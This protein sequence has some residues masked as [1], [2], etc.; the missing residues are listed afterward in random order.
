MR[1]GPK[2][3]AR[4]FVSAG[5][6]ASLFLFIGACGGSYANS[7]EASGIE[8]LETSEQ[9]ALSGSRFEAPALDGPAMRAL[10]RARQKKQALRGERGERLT[11]LRLEAIDAYQRVHERWPEAGG[12]TAEAAFR[13]GELLRTGGAPNLAIQE[14][15]IAVGTREGGEFSARARYEI[16]HVQRREGRSELALAAF[17]ELTASPAADDH[18][19]DMASLWYAKVL[20][21]IDQPRDAERVL[22]RLVKCAVA[23]TDRIRAYDE[24]IVMV[25]DRAELEGASGWLREC[26][27]SV[28][29]ESLAMTKEGERIR[30]A[31]ENMRGLKALR[32]AIEQRMAQPGYDPL[33]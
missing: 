29:E 24:L 8:L 22:R 6:R 5:G 18:L 10:E 30:S 3:M 17:E 1:S 4:N 33:R 23:P 16:G 28:A 7:W 11:K 27:M 19:R 13:A 26:K 9:L 20:S 12:I 15:E 31:L 32:S 14:F 25:V 21:E 2:S